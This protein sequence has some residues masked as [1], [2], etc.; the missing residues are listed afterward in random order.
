MS[1]PATALNALE[2][3]PELLARLDTVTRYRLRDD[4]ELAAL[5]AP[6][7]I[8]AE[9]LP[10]EALAAI[11]GPPSAGKSFAAIALACSIASGVEWLGHDIVHP[12]PVIYVA[13][14]GAA[15]LG[16]RV[17]AWKRARESEG[18][19]LG[20]YFLTDTVNM[21]REGDL[22]DLLQVIAANELRPALVI[23]D[24]L[25]RSMPGGNE[26][27]AKD[28]GI[29]LEN[30]HR[31]RRE[32]GA[33]VLLIHHT[34]KDGDSERGSSSLRAGVDTMFSL[35]AEDDRRTLTCEKQKD[36]ELTPPISLD[37]VPNGDSCVIERARDAWDLSHRS[38]KAT[39]LRSL[40]ALSE[41]A[42]SEG[43]TA[44]EWEKAAAMPHGSFY[45]ARKFLIT[46][47]YVTETKRGN[48]KRYGLTASGNHLVSPKSQQ[49]PN[50]VPAENPNQSQQSHTPLGVGLVGR[51]AGVEHE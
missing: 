6:E 13:P 30:A 49:G 46:E 10:R 41:I 4:N 24:T 40:R 18:Q 21:L 11:Y 14:E 32:I 20:V 29:V 48:A 12:G 51:R 34:G 38:P 8:V 43:A 1:A 9:I 26:N 23:F 37:L 3:V 31:I 25:H 2:D 19:K 35:K 45:R 42:L 44:G 50:S 28:L 33:S 22:T 15:G 47:G 17:Q 27:D 7:Y 39:D 16:I 36:A 5:P